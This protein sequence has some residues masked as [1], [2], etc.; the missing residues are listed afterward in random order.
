MKP[1]PLPPFIGI[2]IYR[3]GKK[4]IRM[5]RRRLRCKVAKQL[6]AAG[7]RAIAITIHHKKSVM[8]SRSGPGYLVWGG[9]RRILSK[10]HATSGRGQMKAFTLHMNKMGLCLGGSQGQASGVAARV[11]LFGFTKKLKFGEA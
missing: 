2:V 5:W 9:V 8:R 6:S 11:K 1:S 4:A 7:D 3:K 10:Y